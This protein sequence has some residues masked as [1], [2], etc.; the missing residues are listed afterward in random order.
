MKSAQESKNELEAAIRYAENAISSAKTTIESM[1]F[2]QEMA[3]KQHNERTGREETLQREVADLQ[4]EL[5][6][7]TAKASAMEKQIDDLKKQVEF[8]RHMKNYITNKYNE[9]EQQE[10]A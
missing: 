9:L 8:H 2:R 4:Y 5:T 3:K 7:M 1:E 6:A 10:E